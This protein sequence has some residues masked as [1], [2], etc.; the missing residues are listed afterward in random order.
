MLSNLNNLYI[1]ELE[2]GCTTDS[3]VTALFAT[4]CNVSAL[5]CQECL[6]GNVGAC[7]HDFGGCWE[8]KDRIVMKCSSISKEAHQRPSPAHNCSSL[9]Y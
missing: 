7:I 4:P 9:N 1:A 3:K 5:Y 6:L 8:G 2:Y